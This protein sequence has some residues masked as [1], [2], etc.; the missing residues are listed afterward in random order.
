MYSTS[1]VSLVTTIGSTAYDCCVQ[2]IQTAG[3][4]FGAFQDAG[5]CF[6]LQTS[7]SGTSTCPA[8]SG[9]AGMYVSETAAKMQQNGDLTFAVYNGYCGRLSY[10]GEDMS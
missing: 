6:L 5:R 1:D 8:G 10:D 4:A 3:C 2:C 9:I 7:G